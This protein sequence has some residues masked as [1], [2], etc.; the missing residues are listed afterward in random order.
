MVHRTWRYLWCSRVPS[1]TSFH[2]EPWLR[3]ADL[4]TRTSRACLELRSNLGDWRRRTAPTT[5]CRTTNDHVQRRRG[6]CQLPISEC[7]QLYPHVAS[8][9]VRSNLGEP[10]WRRA[11]SHGARCSGPVPHLP[12]NAPPI[13]RRE[14]QER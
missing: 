13:L 11:T 7:P 12:S 5:L 2:T 6:C 14:D 9:P 4:G 1:C 8:S 10:S 3:P